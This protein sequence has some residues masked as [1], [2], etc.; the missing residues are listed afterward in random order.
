[1]FTPQA[2]MNEAHGHTPAR[3]GLI[4]MGDLYH[5]KI[6]VADDELRHFAAPFLEALRRFHGTQVRN[7]ASSETSAKALGNTRAVFDKHYLKPTEVLPDVR[8]AVTQAVS[9]LVQ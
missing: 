6:L 2:H 8:Q 9:G 3:N 5:W 7:Y 1:M 4:E